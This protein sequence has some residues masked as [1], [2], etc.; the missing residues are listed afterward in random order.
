MVDFLD[1]LRSLRVDPILWID[2]FCDRDRTGVGIGQRIGPRVRFLIDSE[3][4]EA[5]RSQH[6]QVLHSFTPY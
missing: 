3:S 6:E 2:K 4:E 1:R 5:N